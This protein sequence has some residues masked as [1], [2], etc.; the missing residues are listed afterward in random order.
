MMNTNGAAAEQTTEGASAQELRAELLAD[1]LGRKRAV[2]SSRDR[3]GSLA[4][5]ALAP[6]RVV[7]DRSGCT[8]PFA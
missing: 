1:A 8:P 3:P 7:S 6:S 5:A 4:N 2:R